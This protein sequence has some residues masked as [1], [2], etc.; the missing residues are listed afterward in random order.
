M[1][2]PADDQFNLIS[3]TAKKATVENRI[4]QLFD[5]WGIDQEYI[6]D[7]AYNLVA[8]GDSFDVI[9]TD[10]KKGIMSL[11]THQCL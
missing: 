7:V 4:K 2:L 8:Y 11:D 3:V 10:D 1:R 6:R 9:E 5:Q